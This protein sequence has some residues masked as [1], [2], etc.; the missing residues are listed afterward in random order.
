MHLL[1]NPWQTQVAG[2]GL[3]WAVQAMPETPT[4]IFLGCLAKSLS[5]S[6]SQHVFSRE[7]GALN[8]CTQ[9]ALNVSS[10][11][12]VYQKNSANTQFQCK[13]RRSALAWSL[14]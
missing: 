2:H 1:D 5:S 10:A 11:L 7:P 4:S 8:A 14:V 12:E 3:K 6:E 9:R 13:L